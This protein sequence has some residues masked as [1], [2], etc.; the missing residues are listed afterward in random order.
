MAAITLTQE[1]AF[2]YKTIQ[3][4]SRDIES[5]ELKGTLMGY[6]II[7]T[8]SS[9]RKIKL[10]TSNYYEVIHVLNGIKLAKQ[11]DAEEDRSNE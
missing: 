1:S 3:V 2:S 4:D 11:H 9:G 7:L 10:S 6:K 5:Y 8:L